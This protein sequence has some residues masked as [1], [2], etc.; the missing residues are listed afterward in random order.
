MNVSFNDDEVEVLAVALDVAL[1]LLNGAEKRTISPLTVT[2]EE[3][4]DAL[5]ETARR[6]AIKRERRRFKELRARLSID[7]DESH[8][9]PV[10]AEF[11]EIALGVLPTAMQDDRSEELFE[12]WLIDREDEE[13]RR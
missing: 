5:N 3:S 4:L 6:E 11:L 7:S 12:Q 8:G 1:G 13:R 2:G 9:V 10:S